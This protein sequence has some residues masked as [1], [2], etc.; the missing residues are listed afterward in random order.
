LPVVGVVVT[1]TEAAAVV[2]VVIVQ[3]FWARTLVEVP[4]LSLL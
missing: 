2:L 1:A 4:P 3:V